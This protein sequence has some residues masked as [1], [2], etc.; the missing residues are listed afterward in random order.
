MDRASFLKICGVLGIG[1]PFQSLLSSCEKPLVNASGFNGK[2]VIIGAGAGGLSAGYLLSQLGVDFEILEASSEI[3]GRMKIDPNFADF[4]IPLGAEWIETKTMTLGEIVNDDKV[5]I[6]LNFVE[7]DAD[8]KFVRYSWLNFFEDYLLPSVRDKIRYQEVVQSIKYSENE[9]Q[10]AS[11]KGLFSADRVIISVP[12]KVLQEGGIFF[13]PA[14]P[15]NKSEAI[16]NATIWEGFKAFFEF[17][18]PFYGDG[19]SVPVSP[20][21]AGQK[22]YYDAALG[23]NS[24]HHILGLFAVGEPARILSELSSEEL[25]INVLGELDEVYN[26]QASASYQ[27]HT[28][29]NWQSEPHIRAGYLSDHE[30]WR[31]VKELGKSINNKVY[32]A[33]GEY[34]D[35]EDWVSVHTAAQSARRAVAELLS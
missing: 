16:Q 22:I 34:T 25:K 2:V 3:G 27:K 35:G 5:S 28:S 18:I 8:Y 30:D 9:V 19:F 11:S 13:Q 32:F 26:G 15:A 14:L 31:L 24:N 10:V 33:G 4:P 23:Q 12:L 21:E 1:L 17:S 20:K 7:D 6:G 29:Q